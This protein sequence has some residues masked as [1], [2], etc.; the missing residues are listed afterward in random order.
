M[1]HSFEMW[2]L[3]KMNPLQIHRKYSIKIIVACLFSNPIYNTKNLWKHRLE[4]SNLTISTKGLN[5]V[6]R[7]YKTN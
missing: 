4:G 1:H 3:I 5:S 6:A 2:L 7:P